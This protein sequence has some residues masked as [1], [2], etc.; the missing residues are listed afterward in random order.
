MGGYFEWYH[1]QANS[2]FKKVIVSGILVEFLL[3]F[4]MNKLL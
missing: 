2:L 1:I 4:T 3:Q